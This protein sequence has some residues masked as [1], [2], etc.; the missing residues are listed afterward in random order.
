MRVGLLCLSLLLAVVCWIAEVAAVPGDIPAATT[1]AALA[2]PSRWRFVGC[3]AFPA[4]EL[5]DALAASVDVIVAS[6]SSGTVD[7]LIEVVTRELTLGY[8]SVGF[9]DA[10]ITAESDR[11]ARQ[12]VII[13]DEGKLFR[14]G[15]VEV[16]GATSID[17]DRLIS[18]VKQKYAPAEAIPVFAGTPAAGEAPLHWIKPGGQPETLH[19]AIWNPG[20]P[21]SFVPSVWKTWEPLVQLFLKRQGYSDP[22]VSTSVEPAEDGTATLVISIRDEGPRIVLGEIE[23]T[24]NERNSTEDILDHLQLKPGQPFDAMQ[25]ARLHWQLK[26]TARFLK[27]DVQLISPPF[28]EGPSRLKLTLVEAPRVPTLKEAFTPEQQVAIRAA[29]WLSSQREYDWEI[30]LCGRTIDEKASLFEKELFGDREGTLRYILSPA[31]RSAMLEILTNDRE[32]QLIWGQVLSVSPDSGWLLAPHRKARLE[33]GGLQATLLLQMVVDVHPPDAEG[34]MSNFNFGTGL[35]SQPAKDG[36]PI[37]D[38]IAIAPLAMILE[39]TKETNRVELTDGR[40]TIRGT[41]GDNDEVF[42]LILDAQTGRLITWHF[43]YDGTRVEIRMGKQIH[44]DATKKWEAQRAVSQNRLNAGATITSLLQYVTEEARSI[45]NLQ[46]QRLPK[47]FRLAERLVNSGVL[48]PLD[49]IVAKSSEDAASPTRFSIPVEPNPKSPLG[50]LAWLDP[51]IRGALPFYAK[52]FPRET[53]GWTIGRE[54]TLMLLQP[55]GV[56]IASPFGVR[57]MLEEDRAGPLHFLLAAKLFGVVSPGHRFVLANRGLQE[58]TPESFRRDIAALLNEKGVASHS[59][60]ALADLLR[61]LDEP[62]LNDL[63]AMLSLAEDDRTLVARLLKE[64]TRRRDEPAHILLPELAEQA[65]PVLRP[66]VEAALRDLGTPPTPP[67][68]PPVRVTS[69]PE[70]TTSQT[71]S[72]L[73]RPFDPLPP[74]ANSFKPAATEQPIVPTISPTVPALK[75]VEGDAP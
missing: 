6:R 72:P 70:R 26:Q 58:L 49:E 55:K 2:D 5:R 17:V 39:V 43:G 45:E 51:V 12:L 27:H 52:V 18:S 34:R 35:N 31:D 7:H 14:Q 61:S 47:W 59:A 3:E 22:V 13:I 67:A 9:P 10:S 66:H 25:Q 64:L 23:V 28:G 50:A 29:N 32:G 4:E 69:K 20:Q 56:E 11:D 36:Q 38:V 73:S 62:D 40:M 60:N 8:R 68:Q 37:R 75:P 54:A 15:K 44:A 16:R 41:P 57:L 24:G 74:P 53:P 19:D 33:W 42:E 21:A 46:S 1:V 71:E 48:R 65:W 30:T 63:A